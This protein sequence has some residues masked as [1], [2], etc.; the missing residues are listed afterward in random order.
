MNTPKENLEAMKEMAND[1]YQAARE[2][3]DINLRIWNDMLKKQSDMFDLWI[4][5][6]A[7]QVELNTTVKDPKEYMSSQATLSRELAEKLIADGREAVST[8]REIQGEYQAWYEKSVQS[9]TNVWN[10]ASQPSN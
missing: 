3:S 4:E 10:K 7:K 2:L 5:V 1:G 6:G 9:M 8:S